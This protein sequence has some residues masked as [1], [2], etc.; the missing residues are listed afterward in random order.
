MLTPGQFQIV[1]AALVVLIAAGVVVLV[2]VE[3]RNWRR[4]TTVMPGVQLLIR[5]LGGVLMLLL[6]A[7]LLGG[8]LWVQLGDLP[9]G[10][11]FLYWLKCVL[12]AV[13]LCLVAI[14]DFGLVMRQRSRQRQQLR[15]LT[16]ETLVDTQELRP[17]S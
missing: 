17:N 15:S 9:M 10:P 14:L 6:L 3:I 16:V 2:V 4:K 12:L 13:A 5:V 8:I 7:H 11:F 1:G